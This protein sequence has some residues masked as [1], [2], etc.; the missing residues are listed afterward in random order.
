MLIALMCYM[1]CF[2]TAIYFM[3]MSEATKI[4]FLGLGNFIM[5]YIAYS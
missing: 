1:M 2:N 4:N 5:L 3:A